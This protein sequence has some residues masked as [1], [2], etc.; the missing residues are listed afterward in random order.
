M[1]NRNTHRGK[2]PNLLEMEVEKDL[3]HLKGL[4][5]KNKESKKAANKEN[6]IFKLADKVRLKEL[7]YE[8]ARSKEEFIRQQ[9]EGK[10]NDFA[11]NDP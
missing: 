3:T 9:G 8:L 7:V 4:L 6:Q 1:T 2:N 5:M 10:L 11:Y